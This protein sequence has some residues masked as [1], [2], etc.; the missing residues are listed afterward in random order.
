VSVETLCSYVCALV[1]IAGIR[2]R[3][4]CT[5]KGSFI[6]RALTLPDRAVE[7]GSVPQIPRT[8]HVLLITRYV[9]IYI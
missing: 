2:I 1:R 6:R 5:W 7:G 9:I 3:L 8:E 4:E